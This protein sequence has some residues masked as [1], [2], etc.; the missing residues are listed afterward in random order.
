MVIPRTVEAVEAGAFKSC[1]VKNL[2]FF[3][4]LI[5]L[6]DESFENCD[7]EG[8]SINAAGYPRY[9]SETEIAYFADAIDRLITLKDKKS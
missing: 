5:S 2:C 8:V 7:I 1:S 9:Q 3:D 4:T 6:S